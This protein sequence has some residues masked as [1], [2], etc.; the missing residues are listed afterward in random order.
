MII[1]CLPGREGATSSLIHVYSCTESLFLSH[2]LSPCFP[3]L[4][5]HHLASSTPPCYLSVVSP[6]FGPLFSYHCLS[7]ACPIQTLQQMWWEM[8][9]L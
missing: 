3:L 9:S 8:Q 6:S 1:I 7:Y 5:A 2:L 4:L